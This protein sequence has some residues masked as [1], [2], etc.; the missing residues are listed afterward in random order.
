MPRIDMTEKRCDGG[1]TSS[2]GSRFFEV[3]SRQHFARATCAVQGRR[4]RENDAAVLMRCGSTE[5]CT[6]NSAPFAESPVRHTWHIGWHV[7]HAA[8][9]TAHRT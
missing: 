3:R 5:F 8:Y 6:A 1:Q 2:A 7:S 9:R 4:H